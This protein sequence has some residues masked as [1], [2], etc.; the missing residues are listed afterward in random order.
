M[1]HLPA[2]FTCLQSDFQSERIQDIW[3][4]KM[5]RITKQHGT[6]SIHKCIYTTYTSDELQRI[7]QLPAML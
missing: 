4:E 2:D 1:K 5:H 3:K 7:Y 6:T